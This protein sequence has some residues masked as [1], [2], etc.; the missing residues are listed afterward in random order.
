MKF[1]LSQIMKRAWKLFRKYQISFSEALHRSWL[2][3][4]CRE[5]NEKRVEMAKQAAGLLE[6]CKTWSEWKKLGYMVS[7]GSKALF[8]VDLIYASKG[9]GSIYRA[10]FFGKS[11]VEPIAE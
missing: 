11:Q 2:S 9:D 8:G 6:E 10:R 3:A 4:K 1:N 5:I 7:H